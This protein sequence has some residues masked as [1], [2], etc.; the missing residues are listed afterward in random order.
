M[1]IIS[2]PSDEKG[3]LK[4]KIRETAC[5]SRSDEASGQNMTGPAPADLF[6]ILPP[7][8]V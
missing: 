4:S 8:Q 2:C 7:C 1:E 3:A 5:K 6:L